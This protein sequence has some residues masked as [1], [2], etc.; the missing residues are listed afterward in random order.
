MDNTEKFTGKGADYAAAR[1][2]YAP[3]FLRYLS[4]RGACSGAVVADIGA[5]TGK[6][7]AALLDLGCSVAAVEPNAD[8]RAEADA[9]LIGRPGYRSVAAKAEDT[10]LPSGSVDLV[11]A[12]QAFHWFDAEAFRREC[13]R[14]LKPGG[15][16][17][18]VWNLRIASAAVNAAC[19]EVCRTHCAAFHGFTAGMTEDDARVAAFFTN[20]CEKR[21]FP[22]D[23][24]YTKEQFIRRQLSS[25][26]APAKGDPARA[27]FAGA[28]AALFD[29][30]AADG[31]L[32]VPNATVSY[33]GEPGERE[34]GME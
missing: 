16:V 30:Y 3:E 20:G 6:L 8:M 27:G 1:P 24:V 18:L 13:H 5:G 14:I 19:E 33:L 31:L 15:C 28:L 4:E 7:T 25:S 26:Y 34:T 32:T 29:A 17:V 9:L 21:T 11:T 10:E 23:L 22:N 12:A 2:A